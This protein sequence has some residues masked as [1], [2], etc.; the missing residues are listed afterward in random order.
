MGDLDGAQISVILREGNANFSKFGL[1]NIPVGGHRI[2]A[3]LD[4]LQY[5]C[6]VSEGVLVFL[7]AL[8]LI[9]LIRRPGHRSVT[10]LSRNPPARPWCDCSA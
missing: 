1:H 2:T 8:G 10:Y 5:I 6:G 9:P 7:T 3:Y 4:D